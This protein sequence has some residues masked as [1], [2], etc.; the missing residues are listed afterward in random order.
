V[1]VASLRHAGAAAGARPVVTVAEISKR[2]V[3]IGPSI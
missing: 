1:Y 2:S 3:P